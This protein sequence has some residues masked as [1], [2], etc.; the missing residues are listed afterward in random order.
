MLKLFLLRLF[1]RCVH[2]ILLCHYNMRGEKI[3]F[4]LPD[5][6]SSYCLI[7]LLFFF[8]LVVVPAALESVRIRLH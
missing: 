4:I 1:F 8:N 7:N 3:I 2:I 5:C 6:F